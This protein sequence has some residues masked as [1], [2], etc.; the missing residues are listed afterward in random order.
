ME[1]FVRIIG[2][3]NDL[4]E[5]SKSLKSPELSI[6]HDGESY[7]L[8]TDEFNLLDDKEK[9]RNKAVEIISL[10]NGAAGLTLGIRTPIEVSHVVKLNDDGTQEIFVCISNTITLRDSISICIHRGDGTIEEIHQ[11][12]PIPN[13]ISIA[14]K[15][16]T[17]AKALR[18]FGSG[19]Y[20]WVNLYRIYEVIE[21]D[22]GGL[23]NIVKEGWATKKM[24]NRFTHTANSPGAIGDD[25][26]HGTESTT[27]PRDP[28]LLSEAKSFVITLFHSWLALKDN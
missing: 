17:V 12:D 5:L 15:D 18:L 4:D 7:I 10:I 6:S 11:S 19:A 22:M 14:K 26:R 24:L 28:M 3:I 1:W 2:D 16:N 25:S 8:K 13:W 27:P 23:K 21:G 20:D 9:V